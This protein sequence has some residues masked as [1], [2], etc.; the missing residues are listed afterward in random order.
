MTA[1]LDLVRLL[2][3]IPLP[4]QNLAGIAAG[5]ILQR[6]APRPLVPASGPPSILLRLAGG[7]SLA[8][9]VALILWAWHA[10]R[11]TRLAT[12]DGLVTS[13]PYGLSR[14]PMYMRWALV[15][16]GVGL[17][18]NDAWTT[19]ALPVASA[20]VHREVLREEALLEA[21]FPA[22][23]SRY[24]QSVH[25]YGPHLRARFPAALPLRP[26]R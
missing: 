24:R 22:E 9:G 6:I 20:A 13:G 11:S 21:T 17:L 26:R 19:A 1:R 5:V 3:N 4:E 2:S 16:L 8:S 23:F 18:R 7:A 15:H 12:P 14:N 10:A 25:R